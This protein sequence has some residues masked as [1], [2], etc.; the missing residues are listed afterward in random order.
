M[1]VSSNMLLNQ[2]F[3]QEQHNGSKF[4]GLVSAVVN[5][6]EN[7]RGNAAIDYLAQGKV[8]PQKGKFLQAVLDAGPLI[9]PLL[10][11]GPRDM[12][13]N[14]NHQKLDAIPISAVL[15]T[16]NSSSSNKMNHSPQQFMSNSIGAS[17]GSGLINRRVLP[18]STTTYS[19][20][21]L[22]KLQRFT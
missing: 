15:W 9:Q 1:V 14:V 6:I 2:S 18:S 12:S 7:A 5:N 22:Q 10:M 21:L 16:S 3:V 19:Q 4:T 13:A 8:L 17:S 20:N 11:T